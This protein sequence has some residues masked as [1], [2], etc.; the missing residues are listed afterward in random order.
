MKVTTAFYKTFCHKTTF[1]FKHIYTQLETISF[2]VHLVH[3]FTNTYIVSELRIIGNNY[4]N[5]GSPLHLVCNA[6]GA[7]RPPETVD[8]FYKGSRIEQSDV[9]WDGRV[10]ILKQESFEGKWYVSELIVDKTYM[11]DSGDYVCRSSDL[12]VNS[13]KVHI[14]NGREVFQ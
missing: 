4:V 12:A 2:S 1:G 7:L 6:T 13:V 10:E 3:S 11:D 14:L 9:R 8:W 5:M